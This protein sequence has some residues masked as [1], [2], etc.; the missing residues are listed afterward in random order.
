MEYIEV[1]K[2]YLQDILLIIQLWG[3]VKISNINRIHRF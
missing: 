3:S 1:L 2:K